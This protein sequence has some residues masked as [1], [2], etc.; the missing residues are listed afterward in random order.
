M[1]QPPV[2]G[3]AGGIGS[4]KSTVARAFE[5]LGC[6]V[7]DSDEEARRAMERPEVRDELVSWWGPGVLDADGGIDRRRVAQIVFAD[8]SERRRLEGLIHPLVKKTRREAI[9]MATGRPG[10][11]I[12]APLLFE[13][14]LEGEC[15]EIVFVEASRG[16]RLARVRRTRGWDEAEFDRREAAQM[17]L[18]EKRGRC[19]FVIVNEDDAPRV[20]A[21][22]E[23]LEAVRARH[24][25]P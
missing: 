22:R 5:Q 4:G 25:K 8:A 3:I 17:P 21:A 9:E 24:A 15:D 23:V 10:V 19:G 14:G 11:V 7:L 6:L 1:T 12:D 20:E 13:A 18:E 16:V 2:I